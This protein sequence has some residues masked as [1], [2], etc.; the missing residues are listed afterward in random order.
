MYPRDSE[1]QRWLCPRPPW[2]ASALARTGFEA[3]VAPLPVLVTVTAGNGYTGTATPWT[4]DEWLQFQF[5]FGAKDSYTVK[6]ESMF[7]FR[8]R[9]QF[10]EDAIAYKKSR[11]HEAN[12]DQCRLQEVSGQCHFHGAVYECY[13]AHAFETFGVNF[14]NVPVLVVAPE[15]LHLVQQRLV[16]SVM[17][18]GRW[19][20]RKQTFRVISGYPTDD[21]IQQVDKGFA[22]LARPHAMLAPSDAISLANLMRTHGDVLVQAMSSR[23]QENPRAQLEHL[24]DRLDTHGQIFEQREKAAQSGSQREVYKPEIIVSSLYFASHLRCRA[25]LKQVLSQSLRVLFPGTP[26]NILQKLSTQKLPNGGTIS[27]HQLRVDMAFAAYVRHC[28]PEPGAMWLL[29]DSSPQ[30]GEVL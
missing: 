15:V 30:A 14:Q 5:H 13:A 11:F 10:L 2:V 4:E 20:R 27:K 26:S 29:M 22:S 19:R 16:Q 7:L 18:L 24:L 12:F 25:Q 17:L 9:A 6:I 23:G 1:Q 21:W 3:T 8:K 28:H